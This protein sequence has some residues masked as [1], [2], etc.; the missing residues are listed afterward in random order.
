MDFMGYIKGPNDFYS[1]H[2]LIIP[3]CM[4][5]PYTESNGAILFGNT[6]HPYL[7]IIENTDYDMFLAI[8]SELIDEIIKGYLDKTNLLRIRDILNCFEKEYLNSKC[9]YKIKEAY[10][11]RPPV[12]KIMIRKRTL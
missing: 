9:N 4:K 7:H 3:S 10:L 8:T 11:N 12:E 5:G 1:F 2:H 6:S